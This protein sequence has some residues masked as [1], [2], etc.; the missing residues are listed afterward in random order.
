MKTRA[1]GVAALLNNWKQLDKVRDAALN[2]NDSALKENEQ[3]INSLDGKIRVF[4]A[5]LE[6]L[7][8]DAL[9]A[10]FL[11]SFVDSG[12]DL[13]SILDKLIK[14]FD[15]LASVG[16]KLSGLGGTIGAISGVFMSANGMGK[17]KVSVVT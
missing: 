11:K 9:D 5:H 1:N 15:S 13:I 3:V 16:G 14:G 6:T 7:T 10:N 4:Q 12:T 8:Q 2:S 17:R